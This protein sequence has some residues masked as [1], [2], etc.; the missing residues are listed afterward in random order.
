MCIQKEVILSMQPKFI[1][2]WKETLK[3]MN[4][5]N[6]EIREKPVSFPT[7]GAFRVCVGFGQR[8]HRM[9]T[10]TLFII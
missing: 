1:L 2:Q 8:G 9:M 7:G 4:I 5:R 3:F 10:R 6:L